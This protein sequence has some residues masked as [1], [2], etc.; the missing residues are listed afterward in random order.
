MNNEE[1][2][3]IKLESIEKENKSLKESMEKE[4][5]SLKESMEKENNE[6]KHELKDIKNNHLAHIYQDLEEIKVDI[7]VLKTFKKYLLPLL[8][9]FIAIISIILNILQFIFLH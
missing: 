4:N 6:I 3:L 9:F 7:S 5:K 1:K 2:I 8:G